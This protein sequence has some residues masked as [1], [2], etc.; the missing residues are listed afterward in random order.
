MSNE[1]Q[2]A[3]ETSLARFERNYILGEQSDQG[4]H[5]ALIQ[6]FVEFVR[7]DKNTQP[8]AAIVRF[9]ASRPKETA[10]GIA[11]MKYIESVGNFRI[12]EADGTPIVKT[13]RKFNY[14]QVW[15]DAC[16]ATTWA[17]VQKS[18]VEA[19]PF[20][21]NSESMA[22]YWAQGVLMG[23]VSEEELEDLFAPKMVQLI[24][25]K[26]ADQKVISRTNER[27]AKLVEQGD[28]IVDEVEAELEAA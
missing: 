12:I 23:S 13:V 18:L 25:L 17:D 8:I 22:Q 2:I 15:L 26:M 3:E 28:I 24:K 21:D 5:E 16:K 6:S 10:R 20:K 9:I 27:V 4:L 14:D 7:G 19:K 11:I 1:N